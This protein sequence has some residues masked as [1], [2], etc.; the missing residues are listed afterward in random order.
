MCPYLLANAKIWGMATCVSKLLCILAQL[1]STASVMDGTWWEA[2]PTTCGGRSRRSQTTRSMKEQATASGPLLS[3]H[4][5][6]SVHLKKNP[7][8]MSGL[9]VTN[10]IKCV[11][12]KQKFL[13]LMQSAVSEGHM[14]LGWGPLRGAVTFQKDPL[15]LRLGSCWVEWKRKVFPQWGGIDV[16][17]SKSMMSY[18]SGQPNVWLLGTAW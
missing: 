4:R 1:F 12:Y 3:P 7:Q 11:V 13:L 14:R 6:D 17:S 8:S 18:L 10:S 5:L 2:V 15:R 9:V 16:P